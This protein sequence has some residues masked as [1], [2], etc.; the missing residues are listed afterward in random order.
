MED[1]S[2]CFS[3]GGASVIVL[4]CENVKDKDNLKY[5]FQRGI[6]IQNSNTD[7]I[8]C[9]RRTIIYTIFGFSKITHTTL[10]EIV[11]NFN[12]NF[13][14][15]FNIIDINSIPLTSTQK[16]AQDKRLQK[17]LFFHTEDMDTI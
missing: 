7:L 4:T 13:Q 1:K 8:L 2:T 6:S 14:S 3:V 5:L 12:G 17:F 9:K 11:I 16:H 15:W 10:S